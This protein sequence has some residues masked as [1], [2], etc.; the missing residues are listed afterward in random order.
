MTDLRDA[1]VKGFISHVPHFNSIFN[2]LDNPNA[3]P[4]LLQLIQRSSLPLKSVEENFAVD[5]SGFT[6]SRF[7]RWYDQKYGVLKQQHRWMKCQIMT[8]VKTNIVTAV[9]IVDQDGADSPFLPDLVRE[10][11]KNFRIAEVSADKG[12]SSVENHEVI[13]DCGGTPFIAFK[14]VATGWSGGL[15]TKMFHYFSL[16]REEFLRHYHRRSNVEA[17]FRAFYLFT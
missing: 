2:C 10:T 7:V 12:Y 6:S 17:T 15:W 3:T 4:V 1:E 9:E 11:A 16:R 5:S 14:R 8:G 13:A